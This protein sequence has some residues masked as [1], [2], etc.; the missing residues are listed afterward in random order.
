MASRAELAVP[1]RSEV[2]VS[3]VDRVHARLS[4]MRGTVTGF[5]SQPKPRSFGSQAR[6]MQL[7]SGNFQFGGHL[8]RHPQVP[9]WDVPA[10]G[11]A[12]SNELHGFAWLDDLAA[13]GDGVSRKLAQNWVQMWIDRFD[14]GKGGGW[15]PDLTGRRLISWVDNAV[16][17]MNG[18]SAENNDRYFRSLEKQTAYLARRWAVAL[19]G[20]PR[21][22]ALTGL[23]CAGVSL[24]GL[25]YLVGPSA[26]ALGH[27]CAREIDAQG[28]LPARNPEEL[29]EVFT[30]LIWAEAALREAG[31]KASAGHVEALSRVAPALRALRHMDGGLARFHGGGAGTPGQLH[32]ALADVDMTGWPTNTPAMGFARL[33]GGQ[34]SVIADVAA[35]PQGKGSVNAHAGTLAFELTSGHYP[36]VVNCGSGARF[37]ADWRRAGRATPSHSTLSID[38]MSSA[39]LE[40]SDGVEWLASGPKKVLVQQNS[41]TNGMR[42]M[43][44]HDGYFDQFGLSHV[45][46]L[47]L[48]ADGRVLTGADTLGAL[49]DDGCAKFDRYMESVAWDGVRFATRFHLHPDVDASV[50]MGGS[51]ISLTL[52]NGEVWVFRADGKMEMTLQPSVLLEKTR[53]KPRAS[54]QIVLTSVVMEYAT[55]VSWVL[56]KAQDANTLALPRPQD[57]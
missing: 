9:I 12:F 49:T 11:R 31:H 30:L 20:L 42:F 24:N 13:V 22:E 35:P 26:E 5:V 43:A 14:G 8:V 55:Q 47:D 33:S 16:M 4:G 51:A 23:I 38:G 18:Q 21:F 41:G 50:D 46:K 40:R 45:R 3:F 28:G 1:N 48:T 15:S 17:L 37:G 10:P 19:P 27:E 39:R 44:S 53:I 6:G 32:Q 36:V 52:K 57:L 29:L 25:E 2:Q 34:S 56:S 54:Q 7:V